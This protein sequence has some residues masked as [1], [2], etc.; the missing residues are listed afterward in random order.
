MLG[1]ITHYLESSLRLQQ[2]LAE[3]ILMQFVEFLSYQPL[4]LPYIVRNFGGKK[5]WQNCITRIRLLARKLWQIE[6]H[7]YNLI[8]TCLTKSI[9]S[10]TQGRVISWSIVSC[11]GEPYSTESYLNGA[12]ATCMRPLISMM[13]CMH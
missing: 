2:A 1:Y 9:D 5:V 11:S 10:R 3:L 7:V 12:S 4:S 6:V 13:I 8:A